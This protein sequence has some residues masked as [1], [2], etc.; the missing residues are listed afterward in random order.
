MRGV[1]A[2]RRS[3]SSRRRVD[4]ASSRIESGS[5]LG[6]QNRVSVSGSVPKGAY[7]S[8]G[9]Q[10]VLVVDD[11]SDVLNATCAIV[12]ELGYPVLAAL[13]GE[14]ALSI[15]RRDRSVAVLFTDIVMPGMNGWHLGRCAK[16]IRPELS[17]IYTTGFCRELLSADGTPG[18]GPLLP[19]PWRPSQLRALLL[20]AVREG[21][22]TE[23]RERSA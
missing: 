6:I 4:L 13:G 10:T 9:R 20:N 8:G 18:S 7:M 12:E 5:A 14:E 3:I 22:Q 21:H 1:S 19:K 17:V 11:D 15:I 16:E 23:W 2:P